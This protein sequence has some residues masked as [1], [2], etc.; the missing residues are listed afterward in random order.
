MLQGVHK[1]KPE[2]SIALSEIVH[3]GDNPVADIGGAAT[4]GIKSML[5][6]SNNLTILSLLN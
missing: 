5:I 4:V 6:N 2:R 3:I 1:I